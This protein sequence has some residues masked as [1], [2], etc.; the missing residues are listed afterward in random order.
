[1]SKTISNIYLMF[2]TLLF[3]LYSFAEPWIL[4]IPNGVEHNY[5]SKIE[6]QD[7]LV[8]QQDIFENAPSFDK[9]KFI[10][11]CTNTILY[12]QKHPDAPLGMLSTFGHTKITRI[13]ALRRIVANAKEEPKILEDPDWWQ[14]NF[15][16]FRLK[17][18]SKEEPQSIRLTKYVVY[19]VQG[20]LT[21]TPKHNH[22]LWKIREGYE[23]D[24]L[25]KYTRIEILD[26]VLEKEEHVEA[27]VWL[28]ELDALEAQMQGTVEVSFSDYS[29]KLYNVHLSNEMPYKKGIPSTQQIR[30]WYF[31]EV[32]AVYGWGETSKIP[33]LPDV[34]FAG[35]VEN[36]GVGTLLWTKS[37]QKDALGLLVDT[38]GA[39][40]PNLGQFD[41][42]IGMVR[43]T[44]H[45]YKKAKDY[46]SHAQVDILLLR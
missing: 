11:Q 2:F 13:Q 35:D 10:T 28:T 43:N 17:D 23:K 36:L 9:N 25:Q 44:E 26:G 32:D 22:A 14:A 3:L 12:L 29:K 46:P 34:S 30:Y 5:P 41:W 42:F 39:F 18:N 40:A 6:S 21:K 4:H 7:W 19:Q 27:L 38:G 37:E 33:I 1:M 20:S 45:F 8:E 31:R 24:R 16:R 15:R